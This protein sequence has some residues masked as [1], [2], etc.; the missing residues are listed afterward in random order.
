MI[1]YN[2]KQK[3]SYPASLY[4]IS[5]FVNGVALISQMKQVASTELKIIQL[6][7]C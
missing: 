7:N 1:G 5:H 4:E 6:K 3:E 2:L